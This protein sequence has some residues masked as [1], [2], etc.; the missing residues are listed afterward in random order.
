MFKIRLFL[1]TAA[2]V[3]AGCAVGPDDVSDKSVDSGKADI[4]P[5]V[6]EKPAP[7]PV[8]E[9]AKKPSIQPQIKPAPG[10]IQ[11]PAGS[12]SKSTT[13]EKTTTPAPPKV[14]G[15]LGNISGSI[16]SKSSSGVSKN[17]TGKSGS[18][19]YSNSTGS[20]TGSINSNDTYTFYGSAG[21]T[22]YGGS[23]SSNYSVS[24]KTNNSDTSM[25]VTT[26]DVTIG[27]G[28]LNLSTSVNGGSST[29]SDTA[30]QP[31][32]AKQPE[33]ASVK[34]SNLDSYSVI[35][36]AD[37]EIT[38]PGPPGEMTVWIGS[39]AAEPEFA[40]DKSVG[41]KDIPALSDTAKVTPYTPGIEVEPK[42]SICEKIVPSGSE[43]RFQL[44]PSEA[45]SFNIGA[46]VALYPSDDCSGTPIPKTAASVQVNVVVNRLKIIERG[47]DEIVAET[48]KG[49]LGFW[50]EFIALISALV[51]FLIRKK[52]YK[53]FGFKPGK[54]A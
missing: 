14:S 29:G 27:I 3:I 24:P 8:A 28:D 1:V 54:D 33:P 45:G 25:A 43:V 47:R 50:K 49:V 9:P 53:W 40:P 22:I 23:G 10:P 32:P 7:E 19:G 30:S 4:A 52:L 2:F 20:V 46:D 15:F 5:T 36:A 51:L 48:W 11:K 26:P 41:Q 42:E 34:R 13:S 18:W 6:V 39:E 21:S 37:S 31:A 12:A 16:V 35:V 17:S 38:I 44:K